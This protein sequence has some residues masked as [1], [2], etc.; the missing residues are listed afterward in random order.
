[1]LW[2][3]RAADDRALSSKPLNRS[4]KESRGAQDGMRGQ[5]IDGGVAG[6]DPVARSTASIA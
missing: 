3:K 6:L 5:E 4:S 1:M 2:F